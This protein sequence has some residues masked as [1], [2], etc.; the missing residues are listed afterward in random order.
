MFWLKYPHAALFFR[1]ALA[2]TDTELR[3]IA[4]A[5]TIGDNSWPLMGSSTPPPKAL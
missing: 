1:S 5:A 2:M 4:R 3:L